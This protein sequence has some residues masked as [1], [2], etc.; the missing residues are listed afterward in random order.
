MATIYDKFLTDFDAHVR[1][2]KS[3]SAYS[4]KRLWA[5]KLWLELY[6]HYGSGSLMLTHEDC[7]NCSWRTAERIAKR[8][9]AG[10][11][12]GLIYH[13]NHGKRQERYGLVCRLLHEHDYKLS[14]TKLAAKMTELGVADLPSLR[15][16][17]HWKRRYLKIP[18]KYR[19]AGSP[20]TI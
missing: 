9:L 2:K 3:L 11:W 15:T 12:H 13:G 16:L 17:R 19:L 14:G 4:K 10:D 20:Q 5:I 1:E 6:S 8:A 18:N 7:L